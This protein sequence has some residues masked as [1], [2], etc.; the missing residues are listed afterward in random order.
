MS[1]SGLDTLSNILDTLNRGLPLAIPTETVYGLAARIDLPLAIRQIFAIKERPVNHPLIIHCSDIE[2]AQ[3]Y[4]YFTELDLAIG[5]A[6]W[7]GPLTLILRKKSTVIHEVTGGLPTVGVRIP[8]H[9]TTIEIIRNINIP[10]AAPSANRFGK[11]SPTLPEHVQYD[12]ADRIPVVNGG[13]CS[14]GIESTIL[15]LTVKPPAIRRLGAID[16]S[17]L[18][19]W[20][21]EFGTSITPTSGTHK[22]HYAPS[23][24]L[25]ISDDV[26]SDSMRLRAQGLAVATISFESS[27]DYAQ[28]LY[29]ELRKLD[30]LGMDILI[31]Q[32]PKQDNLGLAVLDRL[33]RAAHGSQ[34][35]STD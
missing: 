16:Q 23:T 12:F 13:P 35:Q 34:N 15:D 10:L 11:T 31:A 25:L 9:P 8:N 28:K 22:A 24:A 5:Q 1:V 19:P 18:Q 21:P 33:S 6:F 27:S 29:S 17:A 14:V 32:K 2:M 7:P 3:R 20:I 4:A 26:K 30:Q